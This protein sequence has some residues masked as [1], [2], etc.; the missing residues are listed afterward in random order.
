L[1]FFSP[2]SRAPHNTRWPTPRP[3][4]IRSSRAAARW[5][6]CAPHWTRAPPGSDDDATTRERRSAAVNRY[7]PEGTAGYWETP[8]GAADRLHRG[9]LVGFLL[10]AGAETSMFGK[11][12]DNKIALCIRYGQAG[13]A[14]DER[15]DSAIDLF[16]DA[17]YDPLD[18]EQY[19]H[20][21][22]HDP[23]IFALLRS[24]A[25]VKPRHAR[26]V[27]PI[28]ASVMQMQQDELEWFE[29][30]KQWDWRGHDEVVG[31][32]YDLRY[33]GEDEEAAARRRAKVARIELQVNE[34]IEALLAGSPS[35]EK[36]RGA[37]GPAGGAEGE[38]QGG[39]GGGG[40][41]RR[42]GQGGRGRR[43]GRGRK[44]DDD[45]GSG[46]GEDDG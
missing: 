41:R 38:V 40:R 10:E 2:L 29:S 33:M 37:Q 22:W 30:G 11:P 42:R 28:A 45:E 16:L 12:H 46:G 39:G 35:G 24:G 5:K 14:V 7:E 27:L 17:V 18:L 34:E 20:A 25:S 13:R 43:R 15:G 4:S 1:F 19:R 9:D 3:T 31:L 8:L 21:L 23:L 44:K 6:R 32:V 36:G 26:R